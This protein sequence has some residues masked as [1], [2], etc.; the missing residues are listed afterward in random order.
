M[1]YY[2]DPN[3]DTYSLDACARYGILADDP[4]MYL[5][6]KPS[7]YIPSYMAAQPMQPD[8][9][10]SSSVNYDIIQGKTGWKKKALGVIA[11]LLAGT[12]AVKCPKLAKKLVPSKIKEFCVNNTPRCIKNGYRATAKFLGEQGHALKE[13]WKGLCK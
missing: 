8:S 4:C 7:P 10:S 13:W 1:S 11:L 2:V 5:T 3:F 6:G 12:F 9:F